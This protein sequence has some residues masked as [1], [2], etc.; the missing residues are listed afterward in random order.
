VSTTAASISP[1]FQIP[2]DFTIVISDLRI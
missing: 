2:P 1:P